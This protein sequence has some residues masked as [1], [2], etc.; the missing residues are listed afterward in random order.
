ML[1]TIHIDDSSSK[2]KALLAYLKTLDFVSVHNDEL[3]EWQKNELD[4]ALEEHDNGT[5][6]YTSWNDVKQ[7]LYG[8]HH[9]K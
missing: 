5:T 2:A 3:P 8:K 4:K 9:V 6:H 7:E 1:R